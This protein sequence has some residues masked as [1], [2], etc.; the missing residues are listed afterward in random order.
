MIQDKVLNDRLQE[1]FED[2]DSN[3][4]A[5]D[6]IDAFEARLEPDM[7]AFI[8]HKLDH[9]PAVEFAPRER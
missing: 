6:R 8:L 2:F 9:E 7:R 1:L 3:H 5:F 4:P